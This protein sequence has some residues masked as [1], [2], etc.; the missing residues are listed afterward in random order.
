VVLV[1]SVGLGNEISSALLDLYDGEPGTAAARALLDLFYEDKRLITDRG[2]AEMA[3]GQLAPG[4][5]TAQRAA[6]AAS[7]SRTG[8]T[9]N[10]VSRL[11]EVKTPT[12]VVWGERDRVIPLDHATAAIRILPD[13]WLKIMS[14]LGHVPQVEDAAGLARALDRFARAIG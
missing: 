14:G 13:G 10:L 2:V 4:A 5:W 1:N 7:F 3:Q 11:G 8:Q 9:L 6:A 12:L